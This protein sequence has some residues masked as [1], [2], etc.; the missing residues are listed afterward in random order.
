MAYLYQ[1]YVVVDKPINDLQ[2]EQMVDEMAEQAFSGNSF[3]EIVGAGI[4]ELDPAVCGKCCKCGA[5]TS[6]KDNPECVEGFSDGVF[7]DGKWWCDLCL[8]PEHP[9]RF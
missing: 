4:S 3:T 6:D 2:A 9:K 7:L 1:L 5:W 8:P